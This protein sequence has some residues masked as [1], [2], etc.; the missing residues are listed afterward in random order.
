[1]RL[2]P[3][4]CLEDMPGSDCTGATDEAMRFCAHRSPFRQVAAGQNRYRLFPMVF[5]GWDEG[6]AIVRGL[7]RGCAVPF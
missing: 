7:E 4:A 6:R 1:M 3:L 2:R 5:H